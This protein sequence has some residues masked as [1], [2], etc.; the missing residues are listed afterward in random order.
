MPQPEAQRE[1]DRVRVTI[2]ASE[3]QIPR[4][5]HPAI[6]DSIKTKAQ[7]GI[8]W[9]YPLIDVDVWVTAG[10]T[11][12]TDSSDGAFAAASSEAFG[13]ACTDAG[14]VLLEPIMSLEVETPA[15]AVGN[16]IRD[17]NQRHAEIE[18]DEEIKTGIHQ[19]R[20]R[21]PLAAMVG[22]STDVRSMSQGRA[23]FTLEPAAYSEVP[24]ERRPKLF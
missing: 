10:E 18:A 8:E 9:G 21:V 23:T 16:I 20:A 15:E 6:A 7:G 3:D 4:A 17:L 1:Q 14:V 19:V 13:Q 11:H 12:P 2:T 22:Y 5:F 24:E